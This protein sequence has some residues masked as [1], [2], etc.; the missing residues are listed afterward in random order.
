MEK[1]NELWNNFVVSGSIDDYMK[2]KGV[3]NG[4]GDKD[5]GT[6]NKNQ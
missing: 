3:D 2:F 6:C 5:A 1:S 4:Q